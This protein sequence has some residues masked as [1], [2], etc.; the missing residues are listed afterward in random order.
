MAQKL[1][2]DKHRCKKTKTQVN[3]GRNTQREVEGET[4]YHYAVSP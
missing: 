4:Q 1:H 2:T 3:K